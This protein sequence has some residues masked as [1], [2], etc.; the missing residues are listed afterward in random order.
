MRVDIITVHTTDTFGDTYQQISMTF[1]IGDISN[2]IFAY[3]FEIIS[4]SLVAIIFNISFFKKFIFIVDNITDVLLFIALLTPSSLLPSPTL[5]SPHCCLCSLV[6]IYA[7]QFFGLSLPT[8][9][10]YV[11]AAY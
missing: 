4:T 7:Y 11:T 2:I 8:L 10:F 5:P 1:I 6:R 3:Y 9:S